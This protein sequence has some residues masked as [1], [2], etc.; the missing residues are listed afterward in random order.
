MKKALS[1]GAVLSWL[2]RNLWSILILFLAALLFLG[3]RLYLSAPELVLPE[4]I[5][6]SYEKSVGYTLCPKS[7]SLGALRSE[8]L[9]TYV[10]IDKLTVCSVEEYEVHVRDDSGRVLPIY[11]PV[12]DQPLSVDD[13]IRFTGTVSAYKGKLQLR[14]TLPSEI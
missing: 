8:D 12:V 2:R 11:R 5:E 10:Q 6:A 14:N 13:M 1:P 3:L 7:T 9:C 4:L